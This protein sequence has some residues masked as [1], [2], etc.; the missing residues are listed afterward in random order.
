MTAGDDAQLPSSGIQI[1]VSQTDDPG[2][3][4]NLRKVTIGAADSA[5]ADHPTV[6]V[7]RFW[8]TV[9]ANMF[10]GVTYARSHIY[11]FDK[12]SLLAGGSDGFTL[13]TLP[14]S[15][16]GGQVPAVG[17]PSNP[18]TMYLLQSWVGNWFGTGFLRL[19]RLREESGSIVFTSRGFLARSG[20][21]WDPD[22]DYL[23]AAHPVFLPAG[24]PTH[25]A[26]QFWGVRSV[27]QRRVWD[28]ELLGLLHGHLPGPRR[29]S[30]DLDYQKIRP[31]A[32]GHG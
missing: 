1:G 10:V 12:A 28:Q 2:G 20:V 29:P 9:Q 11:V 21:S 4:W 13:F 24:A 22:K 32:S 27:R 17:F 19:L 23:Y 30:P 15:E 31:A 16:G 18:K 7:N 6:G 14:A 8:V 3:S 26:I 5:W 25:T